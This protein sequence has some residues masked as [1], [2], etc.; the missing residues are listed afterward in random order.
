MRQSLSGQKDRQVC[1]KLYFSPKVLSFC[2]FFSKVTECLSN[3]TL[4]KIEL[5]TSTTHLPAT[6]RCP[7]RVF[8]YLQYVF[9]LLTPLKVVTNEKLGGSRSWQVFED[10]T[11]PKRSMSVYF[12]IV[13]VF[14]LTYFPI[15]FVKPS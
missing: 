4:Y 9:G 7:G 8:W 6:D 12:S 11:G 14:S 5:W 15:L 1:N 10:G 13:V 2:V 3:H